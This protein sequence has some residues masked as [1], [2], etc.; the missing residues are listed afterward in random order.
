MQVFHCSRIAFVLVL[1]FSSFCSRHSTLLQ[2]F[3]SFEFFFCLYHH[4]PT[5]RCSI[6]NLS[7]I[8]R[9]PLFYITSG[10]VTYPRA[11][12]L[13]FSYSFVLIFFLF[14]LPYCSHPHCSVQVF[15][16]SY[17]PI[18]L[19][20][21]VL[22]KVTSQTLYS[23]LLAFVCRGGGEGVCPGGFARGVLSGVFFSGGGGVCPGGGFVRGGGVCPGGF[24]PGGFVRGVLSGGFC[25]GGFVRGVLS[26]GFCPG[27]FVQGGGLSM[28]VL[29]RGGL[30]PGGFGKGVLSG[31]V[32]SRWVLS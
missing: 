4:I 29:S 19:T 6:V 18:V 9:V 13:L 27:G 11:G 2:V 17:Y 24:C 23:L 3:H 21:I 32:L 22:F 14:S 31:G 28:G 12:V 15:Y 30:S 1:L 16:C 26:G 5:C 20:P 7:C 10:G 8:L 25:P